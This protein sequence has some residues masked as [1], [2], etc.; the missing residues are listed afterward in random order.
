[1]DE[2]SLS[3]AYD[4]LVS[5]KEEM[6]VFIHNY[7][8][9]K[10]HIDMKTFVDH[11]DQFAIFAKA[12]MLTRQVPNADDLSKGSDYV[13]QNFEAVHTAVVR[14]TFG[15]LSTL[16]YGIPGVG[17]KIGSLMLEIIYMYSNYADDSVLA[18]VNLPIDTHTK[19][20]LKDSFHYEVPGIES[21]IRS[22]RYIK[23]QDQLS[24][25]TGVRPRAYFDY[26]WFVGKVFCGKMTGK[27]RN[28]GY[29]LCNMCWIRESCEI[30]DKWF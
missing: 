4:T 15:D 29:R 9:K 23:F 16:I 13:D 19:R 25:I 7:M 2:K 26:L 20:I 27:S 28:R 3:N 8:F 1:M 6:R 12:C 10:H 22:K 24:S 18:F 17:Q 21:K 5:K 30:Q 14:G 11:K